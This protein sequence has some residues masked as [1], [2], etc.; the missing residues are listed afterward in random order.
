MEPTRILPLKTALLPLLLVILA[1]VAATPLLPEAPAGRMAALGGLRILEALGMLR[2]VHRSRAGL[3]AIGLQPGSIVPGL[4]VG[5]LG[6]LIFGLAAFGSGWIAHSV[7]GLE[8]MALIRVHLP[9]APAL[10]GIYFMVAGVIG[11]I[12]EEIFFRGLLYGALRRWGTGIAVGGSTAVFVLAH[13]GPGFPLT[14]AIGG[15]VFALAREKSRTLTAPMTIHVL[16]NLAIYALS[17]A[18]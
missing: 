5:S 13:A 10:A 15:L 3:A 14:Q 2:W 8:A 6:A 11:P 16:G 4:R 7:F 18:G 9:A 1:E 17:L 12:T